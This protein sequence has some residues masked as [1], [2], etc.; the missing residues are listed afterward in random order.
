MARGNGTA[1]MEMTKWFNTNYHFIVPELSDDL[2][3]QLDP[4]KILSEYQEAKDMGVT[5]K[6]NIIGPLTFLALSKTK[7]GAIP[8]DIFKK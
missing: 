7:D 6:I 8:S 1:A 3:F 4:E 2:V 5:T